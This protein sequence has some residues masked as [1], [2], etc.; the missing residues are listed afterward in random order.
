M[1]VVLYR[2]VQL[3]GGAQRITEIGM[4][5]GIVGISGERE[6]MMRN[7]GVELADQPERHAEIV[8]K[9]GV[10]GPHLEQPQIRRDRLVQPARAMRLCGQPQLLH[11]AVGFTAE[12]RRRLGGGRGLRLRRVDGRRVG[13]GGLAWAYC[14]ITSSKINKHLD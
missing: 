10:I 7:R 2:L 9:L 14:D 8:V 3:V 4:E 5:R 6:A 12:Q 1:E 13:H 11:E